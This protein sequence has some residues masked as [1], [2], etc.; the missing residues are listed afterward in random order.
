MLDKSIVDY[1]IINPYVCARE[2]NFKGCEFCTDC[3]QCIYNDVG[4]YADTV[5]R[6]LKEED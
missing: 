2:N 1:G 4:D 3:R 6:V 5:I